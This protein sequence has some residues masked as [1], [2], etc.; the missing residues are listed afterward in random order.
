MFNDLY[1]LNTLKISF[2][3]EITSRDPTDT[4]F[5]EEGFKLK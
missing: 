5:L 1:Y 4:S 2:G 3:S